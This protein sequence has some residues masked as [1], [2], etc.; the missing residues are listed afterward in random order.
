MNS[1]KIIPLII[2]LAVLAYPQLPTH[3]AN[4]NKVIAPVL[5]LLLGKNERLEQEKI[6]SL[7]L[8]VSA[9]TDKIQMAW[10]P[11]S[12]GKTNVK[13]IKYDIHLSTIEDFTPSPETLKKSVTGTSQTTITGLTANTIYYGKLIATYT[14]STSNPSNTLEAKTYKFTPE[15]DPTF[16]IVNASDSGLGK[17]TTTDGITYTY[18]SGTPPSVDAILFSEDVNG[19]FTLRNVISS[20]IDGS[21]VTVTTG[22][23]L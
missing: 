1:R 4:E 13:D 5:S 9:G 18:S 12:D 14:D 3:A 22:V 19:G 20:T 2:F 7:A 11:G 8:M 16:P 23:M 15:V 10:I 17:H 21:T 6:P